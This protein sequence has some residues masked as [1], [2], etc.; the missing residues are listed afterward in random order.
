MVDEEHIPYSPIRS[1]PKDQSESPTAG[2]HHVK[3][4]SNAETHSDLD[5]R[6]FLGDAGSLAAALVPVGTI[7]ESSC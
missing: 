1:H 3:I 5:Y 2:S 4:C 6:G 7:S